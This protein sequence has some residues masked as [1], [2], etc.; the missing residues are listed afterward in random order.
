MTGSASGGCYSNNGAIIARSINASVTNNT[1]CYTSQLIVFAS[2]DVINTNKTVTCLYYN[3]YEVVIDTLLI[4]NALSSAGGKNNYTS[5][6]IVTVV[7]NMTH[8]YAILIMLFTLL[9]NNTE[10]IKL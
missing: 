3:R 6:I 8:Y 7:N 2:G 5:M 10:H 9:A 4:G 1:Q